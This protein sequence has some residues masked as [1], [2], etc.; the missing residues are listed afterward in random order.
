MEER[1]RMFKDK[2]NSHRSQCC[3]SVSNTTFSKRLNSNPLGCHSA[4]QAVKS[5]NTSR[6]KE[7]LSQLL[8]C[9]PLIYTVTCCQPLSSYSLN[10]LMKWELTK[11]HSNYENRT[12]NTEANGFS[13]TYRLASRSKTFSTSQWTR[14]YSDSE[15]NGREAWLIL[16]R[17]SS[18]NIRQRP[19][20][21]VA[22][23][24]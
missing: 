23:A 16:S 8:F 13:G 11:K 24:S 9:V 21:F 1:R 19:S 4:T 20:N 5:H 12:E 22:H 7:C 2:C 18:V 15:N 17:R 6:S 14:L 3:Y 10:N